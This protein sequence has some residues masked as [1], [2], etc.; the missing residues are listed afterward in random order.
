MH[1]SNAVLRGRV[2]D[3]AFSFDGTFT[4]WLFHKPSPPATR[5]NW[6]L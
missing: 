2:S 6:P 5:Y 4:T 1:A 3:P